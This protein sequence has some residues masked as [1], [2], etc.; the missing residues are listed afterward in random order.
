MEL[1]KA[2]IGMTIRARLPQIKGKI[3][4]IVSI[5]KPPTCVWVLMNDPVPDELRAFP[6]GDSRE[7]HIQLYAG[8][9]EVVHLPQQGV[10]K[11]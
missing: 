4:N 3:G 10:A 1:K 9:F 6:K 5:P 11:S 8:E 7:Q 2:R